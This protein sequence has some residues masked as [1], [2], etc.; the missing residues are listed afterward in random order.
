VFLAAL[1]L[2]VGM[3]ESYASLAWARVLIPPM[4]FMP[5]LF[6]FLPFVIVKLAT[7]EQ[8]PAWQIA[9]AFALSAGLTIASFCAVMPLCM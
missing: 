1:C 7:R 2:I 3:S 6:V 8:R 9:A 4:N 5:L